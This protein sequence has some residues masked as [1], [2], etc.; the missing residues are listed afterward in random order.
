MLLYKRLH[1]AIIAPSANGQRLR[2]PQ[3][4]NKT[5][6]IRYYTK[7]N[8]ANTLV[9]SV[10]LAFSL[11]FALSVQFIGQQKEPLFS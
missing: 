2:R 8:L 10:F 4:S 5:D 6:S 7:S 1:L 3:V 9:F 11:I